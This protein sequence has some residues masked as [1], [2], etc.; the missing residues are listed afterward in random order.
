MHHL[1]IFLQEKRQWFFNGRRHRN[2]KPAVISPYCKEWWVNG[3]R[4]R[5]EK[6]A[7]EL[8]NGEKEYWVKGERYFLSFQENKTKEIFNI[9]GNLHNLHG[10]AVEYPNGDKEWWAYGQRH[11]LDGPAV[12]IGNKQ[13][14]FEHGEF[15]R[16]SV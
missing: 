14:W 8:S 11:R 6:P 9:F 1:M 4:H 12:I 15:I 7:V 16:C 2:E 3:Q 10:P 13:F 5:E